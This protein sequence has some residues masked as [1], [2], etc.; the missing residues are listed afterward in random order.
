MVK[1]IEPSR[2][3][4]PK[5]E[6]DWLMA[7]ALMG[8]HKTIRA[9]R[10]LG[11]TFPQL[12]FLA[13]RIAK[14]RVVFLDSAQQLKLPKGSRRPLVKSGASY[15][16]RLVT[17]LDEKMMNEA[18]GFAWI[19]DVLPWAYD[20][21]G[22]SVYQQSK[23]WPNVSKANAF[24]A[25]Y[26]SGMILR[27]LEARLSGERTKKVKK[28]DKGRRAAT[29][30]IMNASMFEILSDNKANEYRW[31]KL[32]HIKALSV[33]SHLAWQVSVGMRRSFPRRYSA[34]IIKY[35]EPNDLKRLAL[36]LE[37]SAQI[38][39]AQVERFKHELGCLEN[40]MREIH[41]LI[42]N[43]KARIKSLRKFI[44][45]ASLVSGKIG[46]K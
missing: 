30:W 23:Q 2:L 42:K 45:H 20:P 8:T 1:T 34:D 16:G 36:I 12:E 41:A 15:S 5:K 37:A 4:R 24:E 19:N 21:L 13:R 7:C 18:E 38:A 11:L 6:R 32:R 10:S 44:G 35:L 28:S 33:C 40:D 3:L 17:S 22:L 31:K 43:K 14:V 39:R 46:K 9:M 25:E 29:D 26:I 27:P